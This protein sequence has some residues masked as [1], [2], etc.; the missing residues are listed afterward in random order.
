MSRQRRQRSVTKS[1]TSKRLRR[2]RNSPSSRHKRVHHIH[3]AC[4]CTICWSLPKTPPRT[5]SYLE[6]CIPVAPFL[7]LSASKQKQTCTVGPT[8]R[9]EA[10]SSLGGLPTDVP[11][12]FAAAAASG[13][14]ESAPPPFTKQK[15]KKVK[16]EAR[17]SAFQAEVRLS[18]TPERK[19]EE[20]GK[21][22][23][24]KRRAS[25]TVRG[26]RELDTCFAPP[27]TTTHRLHAWHARMLCMREA[28]P[29]RCSHLRAEQRRHHPHRHARCQ[30]AN[31][32]GHDPPRNDLRNDAPRHTAQLG[33]QH[34]AANRGAD[35][36]LRE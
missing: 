17:D 11:P 26:G 24:E 5:P 27:T 10:L 3:V 9:E 6:V 28:H 8:E 30:G 20:G 13:G 7:P 34:T 23:L 36:R 33:V 16:A 12:Q 35:L 4:A 31:E 15:K 29:R 21:A 1:S 2:K 18:V 22:T 32:K 19:G 14:H 25:A